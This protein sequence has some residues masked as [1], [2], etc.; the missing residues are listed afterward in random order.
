MANCLVYYDKGR[1]TS[2]IGNAAG[3]VLANKLKDEGFDIVNA[4][5]LRQK[6]EDAV[7]K[8]E[9]EKYVVI[10]ARDV[11]PHDVF[12][13]VNKD[14]PQ[15]PQTMF[16]NP[17]S[18][19]PPDTLYAETL[20]VKFLHRGGNIVWLG[21]VPFWYVT[22][23]Q[24]PMETLQLWIWPHV[25]FFAVLGVVQVFSNI[26]QSTYEDLAELDTW[27]SKR[28]VLVSPKIIINAD[29]VNEG[30]VS[31]CKRRNGFIPLA[32]IFVLNGAVVS[33][34]IKLPDG[35]TYNMIEPLSRELQ[36]SIKASRLAT[37]LGLMGDI[38]IP[39]KIPIRVG[40]E[41]R[42]ETV[43]EEQEITVSQQP[44]GPV[45]GFF[46]AYPAWIKCVGRGLFIRL[47]DYEI[48]LDRDGNATATEEEVRGMAGK[49]RNLLEKL[50]IKCKSKP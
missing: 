35:S 42:R 12:D 2:W 36:I 29:K 39:I 45:S 28:P 11:V 49:I 8:N 24:K 46:E 48:R 7:R 17:R 22:N 19:I 30:A 25:N 37:E 3:E 15:L 10:F 4:V 9:A 14:T 43:R 1:V 21:D 31:D 27:L 33:W 18:D 40:G 50:G 34:L 16:V 13:I 20:L 32:K 23:P 6:L 44:S 41:Y 38:F 47:W 5:E 26:P